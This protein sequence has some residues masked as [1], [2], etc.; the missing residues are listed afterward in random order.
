MNIDSARM[1]NHTQSTKSST[2]EH[3]SKNDQDDFEKALTDH[4]SGSHAQNED[5]VDLDSLR[6]QKNLPAE[7]IDG[8]E[9]SNFN[10]FSIENPKASEGEKNLLQDLTNTH[11]PH[12]D[13][14]HDA[15]TKS[16]ELKADN[17]AVTKGPELKADN[18][19][20]TKGSEL[21]ADNSNVAEEN[22]LKQNNPKNFEL[23]A[24]N[25]PA[26]T[27]NTSELEID[28]QAKPDNIILDDKS[29][30]ALQN[31][32]QSLLNQMQGQSAT[33]ATA[34]TDKT[35]DA[36]ATAKLVESI[37]VSQPDAKNQEVRIQVNQD[38]LSQTE[39]ILNRDAQGNLQVTLVTD[40]AKS[41]QTL[42]QGQHE[43]R[44]ILAKGENDVTVKVQN[45]SEN[46]AE[47]NDHQRRSRTFDEI[48][49]DNDDK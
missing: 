2:N 31:S 12:P 30:Q 18:N 48:P 16:P 47:N 24:E 41:W 9:K 46:Q 35:M 27:K 49:S 20:V 43:L 8:Q 10:I 44:D 28:T 29:M 38:I 32:Q 23:K 33:A 1:Q 4:G 21:K 6:M 5:E 3:I 37:L 15:V 26:A 17:N 42:V 45:T 19:A 7:S 22:F 11:K 40:N 25:Q 34:A 13:S 39:I 36:D 14:K